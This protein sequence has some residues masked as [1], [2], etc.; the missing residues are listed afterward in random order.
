MRQLNTDLATLGPHKFHYSS[1]PF[2]MPILPD[3]QTGGRD[4]A[5][6]RNGGSLGKDKPCSADG[7]AAKMDQMPIPRHSILRGI[8]AH[9]GYYDTV[10]KNDVS[11]RQRGE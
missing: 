5:L 4:P 2:D 1:Q 7:P 6:G 3:T 11:D 8:L 9:R 10:S